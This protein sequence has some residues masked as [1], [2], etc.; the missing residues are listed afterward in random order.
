MF[1]VLCV[2][3]SWTT[4]IPCR[5]SIHEL[6]FQLGSLKNNFVVALSYWILGKNIVIITALIHVISIDDD[7]VKG[8][9]NSRNSNWKAFYV[10]T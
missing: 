8:A 3:Y 7:V 1:S 10:G 4:N 9:L 6:D 5:F 2:I